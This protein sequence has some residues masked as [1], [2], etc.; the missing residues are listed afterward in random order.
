MG[1]VC[2]DLLA[3]IVHPPKRPAQLPDGLRKLPDLILSYQIRFCG[4]I[5]LRQLIHRSLDDMDGLRKALGEQR[6][7]HSGN[8]A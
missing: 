3:Q 2:D 7:Q 4:Q 6:R 8:K 1:Y 5:S